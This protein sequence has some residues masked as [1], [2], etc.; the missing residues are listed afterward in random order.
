MSAQNKSSRIDEWILQKIYRAAGQ[1]SVRLEL[2]NS[3][4]V[5]PKDAPAVANIVIR[6]RKTLL[7]LGPKNSLAPA[8]RSG[9]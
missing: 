7:R 4:E 8:T 6:D 3:A 1:P 2:R 9:S 5:S